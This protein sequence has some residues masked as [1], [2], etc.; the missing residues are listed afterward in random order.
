M[1][2]SGHD[3][4]YVR[5]K[6]VN[7]V[8]YI[9]V[10]GAGCDEMSYPDYDGLDTN[11]VCTPD[12]C[13]TGRMATGVLKAD[14]SMLRWQLIDSKTGNVLDEVTILH[15]GNVTETILHPDD[16]AIII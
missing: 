2:F 3:H 16:A 9:T 15:K 1:Y 14:R 4:Y 11:D 5:I 10:G 13:N 12:V 7:N 8:T 6:P